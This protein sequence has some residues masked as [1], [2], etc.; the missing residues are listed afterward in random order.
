MVQAR[1][2]SQPLLQASALSK[3]IHGVIVTMWDTPV[4]ASHG[5]GLLQVSCSQF[6][7]A[8]LALCRL[9]QCRWCLPF[10]LFALLAALIAVVVLAVL[11]TPFLGDPGQLPGQIRT[12]TLP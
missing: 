12:M 3:C 11:A 7:H 6:R 10:S 1:H 5:M 8:G 2:A 9:W 4:G